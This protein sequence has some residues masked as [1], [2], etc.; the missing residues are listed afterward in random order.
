MLLVM[1]TAGVF[2]YPQSGSNSEKCH[3]WHITWDRI[4]AFLP[5]LRDELFKEPVPKGVEDPGQLMPA[6]D[7]AEINS[8]GDYQITIRQ[9]QKQFI[10]VKINYLKQLSKSV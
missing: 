6:V 2:E 7:G 3:M 5:G 10:H 1:D 4:N 8:Q 9:K